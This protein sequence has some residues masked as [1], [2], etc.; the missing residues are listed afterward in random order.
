MLAT[1]LTSGTR[2]LVDADLL[3]R[4][5]DGA[6]LLKPPLPEGRGFLTLQG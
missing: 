3:A 6:L 1:E 5:P 4:L 2:H